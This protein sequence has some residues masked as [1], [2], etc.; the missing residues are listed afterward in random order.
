[1]NLEEE[2]ATLESQSTMMQQP[3]NNANEMINSVNE[4]ITNTMSKV[5]MIIMIMKY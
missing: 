2:L 1:M 5:I 3:V 4:G